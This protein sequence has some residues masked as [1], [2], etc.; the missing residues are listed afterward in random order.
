MGGLRWAVASERTDGAVGAVETHSESG[1]V[2]VVGKTVSTAAWRA[3]LPA[4][5]P[6]CLPCPISADHIAPAQTPAFPTHDTAGR[7]GQPPSACSARLPRPAFLSN[8]AGR[9][10]QPSQ[11]LLYYAKRDVP[12]ILN[13]LHMGKRGKAQ[14]QRE[15][16][17]LKQVGVL[18]GWAGGCGR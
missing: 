13:L 3:P 11:C 7:D 10:G 17:L 15:L 5:L 4:C 9:D 1:A 16:A 14:F 8:T 12:R 2:L 6:A 18:A